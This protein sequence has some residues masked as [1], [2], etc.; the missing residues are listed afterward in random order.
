MELAELI[1]GGSLLL[2]CGLALD[3][4]VSIMLQGDGK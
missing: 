2:A 3:A 1:L 4:V